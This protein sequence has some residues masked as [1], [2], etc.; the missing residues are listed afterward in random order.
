MTNII[1][2]H[3]NSRD[4]RNNNSQWKILI[5]SLALYQPVPSVVILACMCQLTQMVTRTQNW[6]WWFFW[7]EV[8][9]RQFTWAHIPVKSNKRK[10]HATVPGSRKRVSN[11][12]ES[13]N[14]PVLAKVKRGTLCDGNTI[15]R[16]S[17]RQEAVCCG[18]CIGVRQR[19]PVPPYLSL[20]SRNFD[21]SPKSRC[22]CAN[23]KKA[24]DAKWHHD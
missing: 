16:Q 24:A 2:Q 22:V 5:L 20:F 10:K 3:D 17:E 4:D 12:L 21:S 1:K 11:Q 6:F 18:F 7:S 13:A 14:P 19:D 9:K 23:R 8:S 15:Q